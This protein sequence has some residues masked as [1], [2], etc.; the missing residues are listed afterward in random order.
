MH[1]RAH[2]GSSCMVK[3]ESV[4]IV[5]PRVA[6]RA[7]VMQVSPESLPQFSEGRIRTQ[8]E[9]A[10][11]A[12]PHWE[13]GGRTTIHSLTIPSKCSAFKYFQLSSW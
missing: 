11:A 7:L 5:L 4:A 13:N 8:W 9:A 12:R 1:N 10:V 2:V 6:C 3:Y